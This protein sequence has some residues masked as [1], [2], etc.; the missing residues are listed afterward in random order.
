MET[1]NEKSDE[2]DSNF[3]VEIEKE[4]NHLD[5]AEVFMSVGKYVD[6]CWQGKEVR[7]LK[8]QEKKVLKS[9]RLGILKIGD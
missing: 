2:V 8:D 3:E 4:Q 1:L 9:S 6:G 7:L 5:V